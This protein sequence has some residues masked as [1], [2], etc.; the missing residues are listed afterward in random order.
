[1]LRVALA[2]FAALFLSACGTMGNGAL[3]TRFANTPAS[4]DACSDCV[5]IAE[6]VSASFS[7]ERRAFSPP[8][9]R[10]PDQRQVF[11]TVS[12][13]A[14]RRTNRHGRRRLAKRL[15]IVPVAAFVRRRF[16]L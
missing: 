16:A 7:L 11:A 13:Y 14:W 15:H 12:D 10:M 6:Y 5:P 9:R 2:T 1:M 4:F 8:S 3:N